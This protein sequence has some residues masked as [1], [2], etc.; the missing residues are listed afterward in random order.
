MDVRRREAVGRGAVAAV[1]IL[2]GVG[3]VTVVQVLGPPEYS[4]S[5]TFFVTSPADATSTGSDAAA[6][7]D[8]YAAALDGE[9]LAARV[10]AELGLDLTVDEL[11]G[12]IEVTTEPDSVLLTAT[13]TDS[14]AERS[15]AIAR[16]IAA[17]PIAVDQ[18]GTELVVIEAPEPDPDPG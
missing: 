9:A 12:E 13:V 6:A 15:L 16:A 8:S 11:R 17:H 3:A 7:V 5:V 1:A 2:L 14:S 4:N 18:A 10:I